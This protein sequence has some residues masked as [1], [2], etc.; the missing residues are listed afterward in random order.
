MRTVANVELIEVGTWEAST[1][2]VTWSEDD[3]AAAVAAYDDSGY[4]KPVIKLG[5]VDPRFDGEPALGRVDNVRLSEDHMTLIG[6]LVGMPTWLA[7][8]VD[9]TLA[10]PSRSV[11]GTFN[12]E[13]QTGTKHQF[14]LTALSLL[15]VTAPAVSTLE[16][17]ATR[18]GL[19]PT[20]VAASASASLEGSVPVPVAASVTFPAAPE[21]TRT[22]EPL[23]VAAAVSL[24]QVRQSYYMSD[25]VAAIGAW[26]WV[27]E[28][29]SDCVIV[30]DDEGNLYRLPWAEGDGQSVEFDAGAKE[31]VGVEYVKLP[32]TEKVA[33]S[34]GA[35]RARLAHMGDKI[36]VPVAA[37]GGSPK[38]DN[39]DDATLA[40]LRTKLGITDES[41]DDETILAAL[42][43]ALA[44]QV[45][46][47]PKADE[48]PKVV[49]PDG[50]VLVDGEVLGEL[51]TAAARGVEAHER[52]VRQD[53]DSTIAAAIRDGRIT[54]ASKDKWSSR[55]DSEPADTAEVLAALTPGLVPVDL[56][57]LTG[58]GAVL[59]DD[60]ANYS[61]LFGKEA[62]V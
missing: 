35:L 16:D 51:Q 1:G 39:V 10:F 21:G 52:F 49:I 57:G 37:A 44:E 20:E 7:D 53:R 25:A 38:E 28:V 12:L 3:L 9:G 13:T 32:D 50:M 46:G 18:Y 26:S 36:P 5:H 27:R 4:S 11:E 40:A 33:A 17:V 47:E 48:P 41:A 14:A 54:R 19:D 60:D 55:W 45:T 59:D 22:R 23:A 15:G 42:D 62:K 2:L 30:D 6:D 58:D 8:L 31:R 43:E 24:D 61:R 56:V 34:A 29:Y